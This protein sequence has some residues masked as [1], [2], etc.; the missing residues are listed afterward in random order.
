VSL[1]GSDFLATIIDWRIGLLHRKVTIETLHDDALLAIFFLCINQFHGT[2]SDAWQ[3]LVH[4]CQRWRHLIFAFPDHLNVRLRCSKEKPVRDTLR[5]WPALPIAVS[6]N[7]NDIEDHGDIIVALEQRDRV[8]EI[9]LDSY[10]DSQSLETVVSAMLV[11]FPALKRLYLMHDGDEVPAPVFQVPD[12]FMGG[13]AP[14]LQFLRLHGISYPSLPNL[15]LSARGLVDLNLSGIP[16]S[17]YIS[18]EAMVNYISDL[19][20]LETLCLEFRSHRSSPVPGSRSPPLAR[21]VFPALCR[22]F[23]KGVTEYLEDLISHIDAPVIRQLNMTFFNRPFVTSDFSQLRQFIGRAEKFKSLTHARINFR[24]HA[25]ELSLSQP[26]QTY[27]TQLSVEIL[28]KRL[29]PQLLSL[30]QVGSASLLP[31]SKVESLEVTSDLLNWQLHEEHTEEDARWLNVLQPFSAVKNLYPRENTLP[32]LG[33]ALKEVPEER[34]TDVL[35]ALERLIMDEPQ[36]R[37]V[38]DRPLPPAVQE[39]IER[40]TAMR[41]LPTTLVSPDGWLG[42]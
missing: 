14:R 10:P 40:F 16:R 38:L 18:P 34:A 8:C 11:P 13:S 1:N 23:F 24:F 35:P 20:R 15:L 3:T 19:S 39:A 21:A 2:E 12:S 36:P 37:E 17:G 29:H 26:T 33:Y 41:R 5:I 28:S 7:V 31:L 42:D 9:S 27:H 4:V 25:T 30:A 6:G 22:F 32:S